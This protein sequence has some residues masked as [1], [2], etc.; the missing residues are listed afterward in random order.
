MPYSS[1]RVVH[2]ADA[3][4]METPTW[5]RDHADPAV[6]DHIEPLRYP[7]GNELRQTGDPEA[8][9]QDL[10]AAFDRLAERHASAEYQAVEAEEIM[11]RKNFAATGAFLPEDR[12][13]ALDLLGFSSQLVF[14]TFHNR[15]LHDWE[16][17]GD[18][19]L[20]Y[21]AARAHNRGMVEF[22]AADPRLL[23]S[24]YVP[25]VDFDR[26]AAMADEALADGAAALL[27]AS[28][29]PSGHSPSHLGLDPVWARAQEAGVPI[30]FHVGGTGDLIDPAYFRN[31]LPVPPDFH[32][33]EENFRSVDYMGIPG[34]PAQT[35]ATMIFDGVFE[36]FPE[37]RLG[38]IEQGA[39]WVPSWMRQMESAFEAFARHEERLRALS[40]RPSDYVRRQLRFTPYPTDDVG[41]ITEQAGPEVC[42]FSSDYP[43]VEGGRRPL[44][45]FEASLGDAS[46]E[47]RQRF[48]CDNFLDLRG[49]SAAALAA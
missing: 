15:R 32:G 26:A 45:R 6:R 2:D 35:L 4:I 27:V 22:C 16:H 37:L 12:G 38:V 30:V 5:L 31:G 13:R 1:G 39:I 33:G 21:G 44:E 20:A 28:G 19:D 41:W 3:H 40:L 34:P 46:D 18:L 42:L 9:Q 24:C 48:Y 25:L 49:R 36:R 10:V 14:N 11:L 8:Q 17:S 47:V 43:H 29:C 23:P 7:G